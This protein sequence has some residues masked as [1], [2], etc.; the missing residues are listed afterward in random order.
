MLSV[1]DNG[2]KYFQAT[3]HTMKAD[4]FGKFFRLTIDKLRRLSE[5]FKEVK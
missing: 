5:N 3:A 1:S 4:W 2:I